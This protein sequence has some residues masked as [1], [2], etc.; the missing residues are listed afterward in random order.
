MTT[1]REDSQNRPP[2]RGR[3]GRTSAAPEA[4]TEFSAEVDLRGLDLIGSNLGSVV[5]EAAD[6]DRVTTELLRIANDLTY[7]LAQGGLAPQGVLDGSTTMRIDV[8]RRL[9]ELAAMM[10][11]RV[12]MQQHTRQLPELTSPSADSAVT[13]EMTA[14]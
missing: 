11:R 10:M 1:N 3:G 7:N 2:R 13:T 12:E 6:V 8:S 14:T 5:F 9:L 4:T